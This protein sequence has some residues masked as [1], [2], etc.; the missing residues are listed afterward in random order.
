LELPWLI[1]KYGERLPVARGHPS[2]AG[3]QNQRTN[4]DR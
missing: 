1:W 2:E 3:N 4:E